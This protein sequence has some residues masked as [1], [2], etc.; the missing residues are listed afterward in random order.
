M[1]TVTRIGFVNVPS[2][3]FI[4][5]IN[6]NG[7]DNRRCN[8]RVATHSENMRNRKPQLGTSSKFKGV[9][10][11]KKVNKWQVSIRYNKVKLHLGLYSNEIKAAKAY[12]GVAK[13]LH[14]EFARL[15]FTKGK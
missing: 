13:E 15:N 12:D 14:G 2:K 11:M 7:L 3:S 4:D 5:H 6:H 10:W 9:C 8:L 1:K